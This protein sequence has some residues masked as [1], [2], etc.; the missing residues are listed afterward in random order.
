MNKKILGV[1]AS[2]LVITILVLQMSAVNATKPTENITWHSITTGFPETMSS[3]IAGNNIIVTILD[4]PKLFVGDISGTG[5][6]DF[7]M[8]L[9]EDGVSTSGITTMDVTYDGKSGNL[10]MKHGSIGLW[11]IISA[12]GELAGLHGQGTI[13]RDETTPPGAY[14]F[15]GK[16]HFD[17]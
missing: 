12:T 6:S 4:S 17:P 11:R 16:V 13:G 14:T 3:R 8:V 5:S 9:H 7:R 15:T 2:L 10:V 1:F